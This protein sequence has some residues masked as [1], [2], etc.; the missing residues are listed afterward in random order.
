MTE[1]VLN[2][3][4]NVPCNSILVGDFNYPGIDWSSM[5]SSD[6][7]GQNFLDV[8]QDKFLNQYVDFPTNFTPKPNGTLTA[9]CIDLVLSDEDSLIA[10]VKPIGQL[11]ASHHSI[12][13][14]EIIVPSKLI[15]T[16]EL[17]HDYSKADFNRM[18]EMLG[19]IDW[20]AYLDKS[21]AEESWQLFKSKV[22]EA[23]ES[24][25][26]KKLRRN[27]SKPLWMQKNVMRTIRKKKR[28]WKQYRS[29]G[30]YRSYLAYKQSQKLAKAVIKR[31]KKNLE[32]KLAKDI[33]KNPKAFYSYIS[34]RSK[35]QSRVGPLK[36]KNGQIQTD[37]SVQACI[38]N[39]QFVKAFTRK[40]I[41]TIPTPRQLFDSSLPPLS[42]A[43][44]TTEAIEDKIR[45]LKLGACGPDKISPRLLK[46]LSAQIA[47]PI[48]MICRK[49]LDESVVPNDWK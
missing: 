40:D 38:L 19:F 18:R 48:S 22:E 36:D 8:I 32:K 43:D 17:V 49:S 1:E 3:I 15:D 44:I 33:K 28:L 14:T 29:S 11:G 25:I 27:S 45:K 21:N 9:T 30:D 39:D 2:Y 35:V 6:P 26:P 5:T 10:S 16:N 47:L 23:V 31:A 34:N 20:K 12:I 42:T 4:K 37:D 13:E 46:E 24:C 7:L 41:S